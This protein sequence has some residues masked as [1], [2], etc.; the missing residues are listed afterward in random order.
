MALSTNC[1][2]CNTEK[3]PILH[4]HTKT[5]CKECYYTRSGSKEPKLLAMSHAA[6]ELWDFFMAINPQPPRQGWSS[7][8]SMHLCTGEHPQTCAQ[9]SPASLSKPECPAWPP[10]GQWDSP[11]PGW[12]FWCWIY[13]VAVVTLFPV[14]SWIRSWLSSSTLFFVFK[15]GLKTALACKV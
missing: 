8:S 15:W 7:H 1:L 14:L 11:N 13:N 9:D 4:R 6:A 2:T 3:L 12:H 5:P 10:R